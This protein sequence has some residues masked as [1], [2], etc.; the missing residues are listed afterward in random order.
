MWHSCCEAP[1]SVS[2]TRTTGRDYVF[3]YNSTPYYNANVATPSVT[4][5]FT[6]PTVPSSITVYGENRTLAPTGTGFSDTFWT[7]RGPRV[8][9]Q[10]TTE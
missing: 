2:A 5:Q 8:R 10:L 9:H 1:L 4:V 7:V 6:L 3:A